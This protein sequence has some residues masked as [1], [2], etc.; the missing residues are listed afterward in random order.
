MASLYLYINGREV[1]EYIQR[2]QGVQE[3]VYANSWLNLKGAMPLSLS[4]PLTE[5]VHKGDKVYNY[6]DNL[7]PDNQQIRRRIQARFGAKTD[8]PFDLLSHIG[9]DCVGAIQLMSDSAEVDIKRIDSIPITKAEIAERLR[10]HISL[11]FGMSKDQELRIS[12]AGV[13]EKTALLWHDNTWQTPINSTPTT[14]IFKLPIGKIEHVGDLSDSV[15]NEWLCLK[16]LDAFE[17]RVAEANMAL[18]EDQ[19]VL[20]VTRFDRRYSE[21]GSWIQRLPQEDMCQA[22]GY[23]P[24]LKYES[25]KGPGIAEIMQT[26]VS[27]IHPENDRYTFMRTLFIFWLL[28]ATDGHAKNFSIFLKSRGQFELTPLYDVISAYPII[29]KREIKM[30][31]A[32]HGSNT[33]YKWYDMMSRHWFDEAKRVNFPESSMQAIIDSVVQKIEDVIEEVTLK[34]PD[35]FP[36]NISDA[37][38]TGM[39]QAGR[40]Y[41]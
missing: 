25:G 22:N 40:R 20:V 2:K 26:L 15:E 39:R 4:L 32:L 12:L 41:L 36:G 21:D 9:V 1:G 35:D 30:A 29:N 7:L 38:F 14:H 11:P 19:K 10:N 31:M 23:S 17:L 5:Q 3:L 27:A 28:G 18:F 33:H 8:K 16:I 34:L 37:V 24:A 6:F 13:Q